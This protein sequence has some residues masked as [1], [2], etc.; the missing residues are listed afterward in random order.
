MS[1][2]LKDLRLAQGEEAI[3]LLAALH[4]WSL[5]GRPFPLGDPIARRGLRQGL[6][7][8]WLQVRDRV[9]LLLNAHDALQAAADA[10]PP[11]SP[12]EPPPK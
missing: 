3:R 9:A 6:I 7:F 12:L 2:A 8:G 11:E 4:F 5:R 1:E 10:P